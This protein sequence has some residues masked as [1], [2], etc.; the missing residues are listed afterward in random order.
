MVYNGPPPKHDDDRQRRNAPVYDK[1][2]PEWDGIVRGPELP[3]PP[4]VWCDKAVQWWETWRRSPQ[5]ML[6]METD[7]DYMLDTALLYNAMWTPDI[8]VDKDTG[9]F[10]YQPKSAGQLTA[11][12][13]EV[14]NRTAEYGDTWANRRKLRMSIVQPSQGEMPDIVKEAEKT[15]AASYRDRLKP[16]T[17]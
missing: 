17:K 6:M 12:S 10:T 5:S 4:F 14:R 15:V 16:K 8:V 11:L 13:K 2:Q 7:W 9:T 3:G 1:V